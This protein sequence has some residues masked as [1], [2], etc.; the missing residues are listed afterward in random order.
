MALFKKRIWQRPWGYV[1]SLLIVAACVVVGLLLQQRVGAFD[2][3]LL[4]Y[5]GN[6]GGILFV[7][8]FSI[9]IGLLAKKGNVAGWLCGIP[10][11]VT[12]ISIFAFL[13]IGSRS[14][15]FLFIYLLLTLSLGGVIVRKV[16][17][18]KWS[19]WGFYLNHLGLFLLLLFSGFGYADMER[20]IMYVQEGE[21][22]WRVYSDDGG[23]KEL[24]IAIT[25]HDFD[26]DYY[27]PKLAVINKQTGEVL[28]Q[29]KPHYFQLDPDLPKGSINGWQI[30]VQEYIHQAMRKSDSTYRHLPMPGATP[31]V[32]IKA[33]KEGMMQQGWVCGGNQAQLFMTLP[34]DENSSMVMTVAEPRLFQSTIEVYTE[35]E[36]HLKRVIEVNKPLKVGHWTI[37]QYGYDNQAGRLSSYSSFELVYD[38]WLVPAYLGI[39][40]MMIGSMVM[41]WQGK[42]KGGDR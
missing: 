35:D 12:L 36:K 34:L 26:M 7:L 24:P 31:A 33:T 40:M 14:W 19:D 23:V 27:P 16:K 6:I 39:I 32:K 41:I 30:E 2:F 3:Y 17:R 11:S 15:S 22:E 42:G 29:A 37:Y 4:A 20:Y 5:P 18:F 38:P 28:P 25:L 8:L 13:A 21:T 10:M 9:L 1:E